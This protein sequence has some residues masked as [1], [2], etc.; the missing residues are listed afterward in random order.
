MQK[1]K[2]EN[3][4]KVLKQC[5]ICY[6]KYIHDQIQ[7]IERIYKDGKINTVKR[8]QCMKIMSEAIKK[9]NN[10]IYN[11]KIREYDDVT[12]IN[13]ANI[14]KISLWELKLTNDN[15]ILNDFE[16]IRDKILSACKIIGFYSL[17]NAFD[18]LNLYNDTGSEKEYTEKISLYNDTFIPLNY[19]IEY[20]EICNTKPNIKGIINYTD[21]CINENEG[22]VYVNINKSKIMCIFEGYFIHDPLHFIMRT[23]Q[24]CN[25]FLF[26]KRKQLEEAC[27][28]GYTGINKKFAMIYIKN[29]NYCRILM[30]D[31][32]VILQIIEDE[33]KKY[34]E[35]TKI[36]S[37]KIHIDEFI[38][39]K[40]INEMFIRIKLLLMG[41][42]EYINIAGML[43]SLVKDKKNGSEFVSDII[44][45]NLS[46]TL[47]TKLKKSINN[48]KSELE[49]ISHIT[50][51]DIDMKNQ[52]V[53]NVNIPLYIKKLILEKQEE[54][55]H[56]TNE[57]G[58][59]KT[60]IE[61]LIKYPWVDTNMQFN[62]IKNDN[63]KCRTLLDNV[64][65]TLN[66]N[67]YGHTECKNA[68]C[69]MMC[70]LIMNPTSGGKAI[71]LVGPPGIG[72]T[73]IAKGLGD[74]LKI[75]YTII[76]L[77]GVEDPTVLNGHSFTYSSA[78]PG[79]VV[80]K[81][82]EAGQA[83]CI[84]FFDELDKSCHKHGMN[85]IHNVLINITDPNMND[86]FYD[87]FFEI[88]F[89][90]NKV[91][92]VFS[93]NDRT[94]IDPVLLNRIHEIEVKA[95]TTHD[96][97]NITKNYLLKEIMNDIN[98]EYNSIII[99]DDDIEYI[100]NNYT[101]ES[102]VRELKRKLEMIFLKLN[103]DRIYGRRPFTDDGKMITKDN[104]IT[105]TRD[106]IISYLNR[107]VN[108]IEKIYD[109][110]EIGI[111]NGLY[112]TANGNGGIMKIIVYK[113]NGGNSFELHHTGHQGKIMKE[114]IKIAY[115][116]ATHLLSATIVDNFIKK[117]PQGIHIHTPDGSTP[118]DGPSAGLAFTVAIMSFI[119]EKK[120]RNNYALT[121]EINTFGDINKI[122][123][124]VYKLKGA[125]RAN[126]TDVVIP[127]DNEDDLN[128]I[129]NTY[130][131]LIDDNFRVHLVKN[132]ND[133]LSDILID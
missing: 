52:L 116:I 95:Y 112:A 126:I 117:N 13:N 66:A 35:Y 81:M 39:A 131:N 129:K 85:E 16:E 48:I 124:L 6:T 74:A 118:K 12:N 100:A 32:D 3:D 38:K 133:I 27:E 69:E 57:I 125:K 78:Q 92:F 55:K 33:Y 25:N 60:Y 71:G 72:K 86:A 19:K 122:G 11:K 93:Y 21:D 97:L 110:P 76:S 90:L 83:R 29:M 7:H 80:R 40:N 108:D 101:N 37:I 26:N 88:G 96:K 10:D 132:I 79:I 120:V 82:V 65:S 53:V 111:A 49:K 54:I 75:P 14:N 89:P 114:S 50:E 8:I 68:I 107:P 119:M 31:I 9:L 130:I 64:K 113:Y 91:I 102:G 17:T 105:I 41:P 103:I 5:Y 44:Y 28:K 47:Q 128:E 99:N 123:G 34:K 63:E 23:A 104:P 46:Y 87:K 109:T 70:K 106:I 94:K 42:E 58:K 84:M 1:G 45:N 30:N 43:F 59:H 2:H 20:L 18:L 127:K 56:G 77:C 36:E 121:G 24:L 15:S 51:N 98:M 115:T 67:V 22:I 61:I 73:L 4:I 62:E